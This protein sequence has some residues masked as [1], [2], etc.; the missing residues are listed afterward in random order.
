MN[1]KNML[2]NT[3]NI[4]LDKFIQFIG[5]V[6]V[7]FGALFLISLITYSPDDP[8]FIFSENKEIKNLLGFNGSLVSDF[9]FKQLD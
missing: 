9:F 2:L 4:I 6:I 8:N 5:I 7:I 1:F 3:A